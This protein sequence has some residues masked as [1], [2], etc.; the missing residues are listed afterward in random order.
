[1]TVEGESM[2]TDDL[3][4]V[5]IKTCPKCKLEAPVIPYF[6]YRNGGNVLQSYCKACRGKYGQKEDQAQ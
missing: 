3:P 4:E 1:M 6:G 2:N 5:E